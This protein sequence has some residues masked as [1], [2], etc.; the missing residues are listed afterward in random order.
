MGHVTIQLL[1]GERSEMAEL[2]RV[3]EDAPT[4]AELVTGL[5]PGPADAQSTYTILP[6]GKFYKD[7]FVLGAYRWGT[8]VGFADLIR[9][10]PDPT[11]AYLGVLVISEK[12]QRRGIG[13]AVFELLEGL[14]RSWG[15]CDRIRLAVVRTNE[16]VVPF[17]ESLGFEATGETKPVSVRLGGLRAHPVREAVE[18]ARCPAGR[19]RCPRPA[20]GR[21]AIAAR[22]RGAASAPERGPRA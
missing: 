16:R 9:G 18:V 3:I 20:A 11:T 6:E 8:M 7:K 17:W 10:Y 22:I 14:V 13:R 2:Q 5:P 1:K 21:R 19:C 12:H 15:T 4:Y